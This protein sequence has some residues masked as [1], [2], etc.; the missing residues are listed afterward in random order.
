[1]LWLL[2]FRQQHFVDHNA[3]WCGHQPGG[4]MTWRAGLLPP[5][6]KTEGFLLFRPA[7]NQPLLLIAR[8]NLFIP[9]RAELPGGSGLP[10]G[11]GDFS[12]AKN[13]KSV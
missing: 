12:Q 11:E 6:R 7:G 8:Q 4:G 9:D 13:R 10:G 5:G 1:M 2:V 3:G